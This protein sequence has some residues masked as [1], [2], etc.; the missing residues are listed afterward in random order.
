[1]G[2]N[3]LTNDER[4][5]EAVKWLNQ[6]T[7]TL[8]DHLAALKVINDNQ[9]YIDLGFESMEE[10]CKETWDYAKRTMYE[11]LQVANKMLPIL[12]VSSSVRHGAQ[13]VHHTEIASLPFKKLLILS[14]LEDQ[15]LLNFADT[16]FLKIGDS[17]Y[18]FEDIKKMDR[19]VLRNL[20]I[21]NPDDYEETKEEPVGMKL[22]FDKVYSRAEKYFS[23]LLLDIYN[24]DTIV[25]E[26]RTQI[27]LLIR[28][29]AKIFDYY[30]TNGK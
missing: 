21:I 27:D 1:M 15:Q 25:N 30:K 17:V 19:N 26:H 18:T 5:K 13:M 7:G 24:C 11:Q 22:P 23:R 29:A 28:K 9:Y 4:K 16:G 6:A 14:T 12:S 10:L 3:D 20:I 2:K 8:F